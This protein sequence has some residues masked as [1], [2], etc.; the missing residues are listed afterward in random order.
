MFYSTWKSIESIVVQD[1]ITLKPE[2]VGMIDSSLIEITNT[3][4]IKEIEYEEFNYRNI[5][6]NEEIKPKK[7]GYQPSSNSQNL[8]NRLHLIIIILSNR[9][10]KGFIFSNKNICNNIVSIKSK[11]N[12]ILNNK[13][14]SFRTDGILVDTKEEL[15]QIVPYKI[16]KQLKNIS[17]KQNFH[18]EN[19]KNSKQEEFNINIQNHPIDIQNNLEKNCIN[20]NYVNE[21]YDIKS[22]INSS[23]KSKFNKIENKESNNE[24]NQYPVK[25]SEILDLGNEDNI[26]N[27][28]QLTEKELFEKE[29][30]DE[31][32]IKTK[33]DLNELPIEILLKVDKRTSFEYLW[34]DLKENHPIINIILI[35]S[36][37][38]PFFIRLLE[39]LFG[40]SL[41]FCLNALFF[42]DDVIDKQTE[43]KLKKGSNSIGLVYVIV[44]DFA[45]SLWPV[46]ITIIVTTLIGY[47]RKVP[48]NYKNTIN[49]SLL[50]NDKNEVL[51]GM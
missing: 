11:D 28:Q 40:W 38:N 26:V 24:L 31:I 4:K 44:H 3:I 14:N 23:N 2:T 41:E 6:I 19:L 15:N 37:L 20:N 17:I 22:N 27:F 51:L 9:I 45:K 10:C 46:I 1:A 13:V 42:T 43:E 36:I 39:I 25:E 35:K 49:S 50:S 32:I 47:L 21:F 18:E 8:N 29:Y 34:D 12:I 30:T 33:G 5:K 16:G 7:S 48:K